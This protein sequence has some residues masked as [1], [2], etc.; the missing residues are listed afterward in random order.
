MW[1]AQIGKKLM[2]AVRKFS[3]RRTDSRFLI[4]NADDFGHCVGVNRG[5]FEAHQSG[6]VTSCSLMVER[7]AAGEAAAYSGVHPDLSLGL[8][9]NLGQW[10]YR[11][12][13]WVPEYQLVP[14]DDATAVAGAV[15]QQLEMF[16]SLTGRNPTH[17]DS[18]QHVHTEEPVRSVLLKMA[19][20][21]GVPL[22]FCTPVTT[23]PG[24][25]S[26]LLR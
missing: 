8:H 24:S 2:S 19:R 21:L 12:G 13:N 9:L 11:D 22:R 20:R 14:M 3:P 25:A 1:M 10:T 7:P 16:R 6:I 23:I 26:S 18:H 4:V 15:E 5:I 17:I